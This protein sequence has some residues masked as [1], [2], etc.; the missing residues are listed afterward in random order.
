MRFDSAD[1]GPRDVLAES[2]F[3]VDHAAPEQM[4]IVFY[5]SHQDIVAVLQ[6][7]GIFKT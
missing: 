6:D 1:Y 5:L 2:T 3:V 4:K 7:R